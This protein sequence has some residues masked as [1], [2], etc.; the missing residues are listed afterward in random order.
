MEDLTRR[1]SIHALV[2]LDTSIWIY[3]LEANE[4]YLGLTTQIL[5]A[6]RVGRPPAL[7]SVITLME[8]NVRP[9]KLNQPGVALHYEA[10][11]A[12]F[13]NLQILDVDPPIARRA[14]QLRAAYGLRPADALHVATSL[15]AGATAWVTND[16]GLSRLSP[17]I[18]V[19]ILDDA[20]GQPSPTR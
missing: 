4:R 19:I 10:I 7:I 16:R 15:V 13:P 8:L 18:D 14:A 3:H 20:L 12:N 6:V 2:G 11:I 17:H 9:Y 1:L 5:N